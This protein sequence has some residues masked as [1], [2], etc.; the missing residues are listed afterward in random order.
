M[1]IK[2]MNK[3]SSRMM[4]LISGLLIGTTTQAALVGHWA[5]DE[6]SGTT[7]SNSAAAG[8]YDG[9]VISPVWTTNGVIGGALELNGTD[10]TVWNFGDVMSTVS[11]EITVSFW[12]AR[13]VVA[14][15]NANGFSAYTATNIRELNNHLPFDTTVYWDAGYVGTVRQ[16][17]Q[18]NDES[19]FDGRWHHWAF[20][21]NAASGDMAIYHDGAVVV[22]GTNLTA[23][24]DSI[25]KFYIGSEGGKMFFKGMMDD[26]RV[27]DNELS[28]TEISNL[29][30]AVTLDYA[31]AYASATPETG[32]IPFDV[33][34]DGS[35]SESSTNISDYSWDFGD[36]N[37]GYGMIVTNTYTMVGT[38]TA[39]LT[40]TDESGNTDTAQVEVV[41]E[42][43]LVG[44]PIQAGDTLA[45]DFGATPSAVPNYND[46]IYPNLGLSGLVRLSDGGTT[47]V[48]LDVVMNGDSQRNQ[49]SFVA[50]NGGNTTD[51]SVYADGI[52]L[53][54][55]GPDNNSITLTF[56]GL[57]DTLSY[58]IV[59]GA[60]DDDAG[61]AES[62]STDWTIGGIT[63]YSDCTVSNGYVNFTNM[64]SSGGTLVIEITD[65]VYR[66][67]V[68]QVQLTAVTREA[69]VPTL[70]YDGNLLSWETDA[71]FL[72]SIQSNLN[73][74]I[75]SG[76]GT[77]SNVVGTPPTT[78]VVLPPKNQ[79]AEFFRVIV[80]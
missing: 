21:K 43:P 9:T 35:L 27:Y 2:N 53:W 55:S 36:G 3:V 70:V 25:T 32:L 24:L 54:N 46:I 47:L 77:F 63:N 45:I 17:I 74:N 26:F 12:C 67:C 80:E 65:A 66:A 16:R 69:G 49:G 37:T 34:F 19:L 40:V 1:K 73:L 48:S 50:G 31:I 71:A 58:N 22:A 38:H 23:S 52:A 41:V 15:Q 64:T 59:G 39:T 62:F 5:F 20:T 30:S 7:A 60:A 42:P 76:W 33:V 78:T 18:L 28:A 10:C 68:A 14:N 44:D 57:D 61:L 72:Y 75:E 51:A 29:Y 79:D 11:D 6:T 8:L 13:D 4:M 56:T